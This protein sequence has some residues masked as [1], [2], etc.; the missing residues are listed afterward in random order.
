MDFF[1]I[2]LRRTLYGLS[3]DIDAAF[4]QPLSPKWDHEHNDGE[5]IDEASR[6]GGDRQKSK[7]NYEDG[8]YR[9]FQA[10]HKELTPEGRLVVVFA[11]KQPDAWETLVSAIIRA[12]FVVDGS[13]PIQTEMAIVPVHSRRLRSPHPSGW[14]AR[15]ARK[16]PAQVGIAACWKRCKRR[17]F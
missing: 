2:W 15:N 14:S 8:M 17:L 16:Q 7:T 13:W 3:P 10:C 12:G 11:H 9:V 4:K 1:Y 6:F 5:L